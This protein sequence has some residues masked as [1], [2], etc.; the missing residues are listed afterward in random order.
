MKDMITTAHKR[1]FLQW[2]LAHYE[3]KDPLAKWL[4]ESILNHEELL[5]HVHFTEQLQTSKKAL[6]IS[7]KCV[8]MTAFKFYHHHRSSTDVEKAYLNLHQ[9]PEQD[10]YITLYFRNRLHSESFRLVLEQPEHQVIRYAGQRLEALQIELFLDHLLH[11]HK[12]QLIMRELDLALDQRD[13]ERF[14]ALAKEYGSLLED[15]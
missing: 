5:S 12:L 7:T 9:N 11:R 1:N 2:F 10:V 4:L 14:L 8:Q 6:L 15:D 13:K 3:V